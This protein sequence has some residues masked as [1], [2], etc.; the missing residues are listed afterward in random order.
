MQQNR[1]IK[2]QAADG[3]EPNQAE[4]FSRPFG[5]VYGDECK[6]VIEK[7]GKYKSKYDETG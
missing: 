3:V 7:M 4:P 2:K 6:G 1:A 5:G